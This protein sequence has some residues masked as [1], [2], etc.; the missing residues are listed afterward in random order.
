MKVL[1][2]GHV[3]HLANFEDKNKDEQTI[4]FI[5]KV[6]TEIRGELVTVHDGT[7]NEEVLRML[8]DR[9]QYLQ[10]KFPCRENAI[11]ITKLEESLMWLE[12]RT[13]DRKARGVEGK[14]K[15]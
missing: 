11:V 1:T 13:S 6:P 12:K 8:I 15:A 4:Q 14:H 10:H 5:N 7:T 2:E 9:M 3:Y